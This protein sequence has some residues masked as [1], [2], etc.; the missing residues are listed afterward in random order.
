MLRAAA[1]CP[2]HSLGNILS[3][4][5][6]GIADLNQPVTLQLLAIELEL[7]RNRH[8]AALVRIDSLAA[9]S[10]R[11]E[12][13]SLRRAEVFESAGRLDEARGAYAATLEAIT[14]LQAPADILPSM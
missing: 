8:S 11:Q 2:A 4:L 3:G 6:D 10:K 12:T 5:D 7:R 13:W 14:A 9:R 1:K